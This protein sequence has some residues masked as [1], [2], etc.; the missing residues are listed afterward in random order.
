M[1]PAQKIR[2]NPNNGLWVLSEDRKLSDD[3]IVS[4]VGRDLYWSGIAEIRSEWKDGQIWMTLYA[5]GVHTAVLEFVFDDVELA[6][7]FYRLI[8]QR[9]PPVDGVQSGVSTD[10]DVCPTKDNEPRKKS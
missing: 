10:Q 2:V 8:W 4:K 1:S 9:L 6:L 7:R 3:E 5:S